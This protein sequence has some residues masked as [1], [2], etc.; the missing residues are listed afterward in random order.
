LVNGEKPESE[1]SFRDFESGNR[2]E[3][4]LVQVQS[5]EQETPAASFHI[6]LTVYLADGDVK[7]H[8]V[9]RPG[10]KREGVISYTIRKILLAPGGEALVFVV[11]KEQQAEDGSSIR[12]MVETVAFQ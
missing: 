10:Y 6:Q 9:G 7:A 4:Q 12:Y 11:E 5:D 3:V 2:F 8:T 1:I